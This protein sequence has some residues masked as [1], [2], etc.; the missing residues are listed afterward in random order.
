MTAASSQPSPFALLR[1]R[2]PLAWLLRA[3][4]RVAGWWRQRPVPPRPPATLHPR[5]ARELSDHVL[6][7]IGFIDVR[8]PRDDERR[9]RFY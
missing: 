3:A 9:D 6:R 4:R 1:S 7:D 8:G 5:T 2:R